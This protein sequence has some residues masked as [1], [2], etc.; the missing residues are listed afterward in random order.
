MFLIIGRLLGTVLLGR[1]VWRLTSPLAF[2]AGFLL[3]TAPYR[4][5]PKRSDLKRHLEQLG[6]ELYEVG[7]E[8][9]I[10]YYVEAPDFKSLESI[11]KTAEQHE[12]V[13]K[14]YIAY[15]FVADDA[16]RWFINEALARNEIELDESMI[17]YLKQILSRIQ[18][19]EQAAKS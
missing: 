14:A 15:G 5:E 2:A 6:F 10:V 1:G 3:I 19:Q 9:F 18:P 17:E 16:T 4:K 8:A 11:I 13:A 12:G 7:K